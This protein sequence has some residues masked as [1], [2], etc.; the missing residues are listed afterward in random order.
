MTEPTHNPQPADPLVVTPRRLEQIASGYG[1]QL[2][3][4]LFILA[5]A[6]VGYPAYAFLR[7]RTGAPL[8]AWWLLLLSLV[9]LAVALV[10]V[11]Y[12]SSG[13]M[14]EGEKLRIILV[15]LG[16][17]IGI[18]TAAYGFLLP[19]TQFHDVFAGGFDEWRKNRAAIGLTVLPFFGGLMLAFFSLLLTSGMERSS[20]TA[21][22]LLYGYN[23]V[24][25]GLLLLFILLLLNVLPYSGVWPFKAMAQTSDWTSSGLYSLSQA[26]KERLAALDQPVKIYVLMSG[27][28]QIS[29]EVD[30]MMQNFRENST[31]VTWETLSPEINRRDVEDL[32]NK[33]QLTDPRGLLVV[34]GTEPKTTWE[35][36]PTRELFTDNSTAEGTARFAFK[37]ESAVTK[38]LTYLSEGKTKPVVYFTQGHGELDFTDRSPE[39]PDQ[40]IG[41]AADRLAQMNY[42]TKPLTF[43]V[44]NPK[45]PDDADIVV[46]ARPR[47]EMSADVISALRIFAT[48]AGKKKGK[49][50]I[51]LDVVPTRDGKM[52]KTGLEP[53]LTEF[54]VQAGNDRLLALRSRNPLD[55]IAYPNPEGNN[56]IAR[57]F[58]PRGSFQPV[59]FGLTDAR[60]VNP[61]PANPAGPARYSAETLLMVPAELILVPE[62]DLNADPQTVAADM[63]ADLQK[64]GGKKYSGRILR[65]EPSVAVTVSETKGQAPPIPG[66]EF[67]GGESQ[68]RMVVF[69]D[70]SWVANSELSGRDGKTNF[71][72]FASCVNWLRERPDIG[73]QAVADKA[74]AEFRLPKDVGGLRLLVLPVMLILLTVVCL[75]TGVWV[76]RRR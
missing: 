46:V 33:Y 19:F 73:A 62:S 22:R 42:E 5:A 13:R 2:R 3:P 10:N 31:R 51:L 40:G 44:E 37:G 9:T 58:F 67:M 26:T 65:S 23:A 36:I 12:E 21:R 57:A 14:T 52:A 75:G 30:T 35:F 76:V 48:T 17:L 49:L 69:G 45:V 25:S 1:K 50:F 63:R 43:S 38:A 18:C 15:L 28:D 71:D 56:P 72:L 47:T 4:A 68:P 34:Y 29:S 24:L 74:R 61:A 59:A 60:T 54:S 6:F 11:S 32:V 16:G 55:L 53:L 39:R 8:E 7:L 41:V 70:A 20:A 27:R 66:H 64:N